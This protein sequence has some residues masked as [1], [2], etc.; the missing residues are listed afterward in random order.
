MFQIGKTYVHNNFLD[1]AVKVFH[2]RQLWYGWSLR[3]DWYNQRGLRLNIQEY[4]YVV[5]NQL[6]NWK[7][8]E[9]KNGK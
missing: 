4:I 9:V 7:E 2:A 5:N 8:F 1:C 6:V 3:I